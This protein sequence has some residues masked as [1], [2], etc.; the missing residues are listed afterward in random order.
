MTQ[1]IAQTIEHLTR[2]I[3]TVLVAAALVATMIPSMHAA[4]Q[5]SDSKALFVDLPPANTMVNNGDTVTIGG[6]TAGSR[7][8]IYLDG[9]AG[10]GIHLGSV[11]VGTARPDVAKATASTGLAYSGFDLAWQPKDLS[12]GPHTLYIYSLADGAW[13]FKT[14]PIMGRGNSYFVTEP[15][16][17]D[18]GP[19]SR[20]D[21]ER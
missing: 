10:V 9:P 19:D 21:N 18:R 13:T 4:A 8:D 11:T 14:V 7:V 1:A 17:L 2:P 5:G 6:W 12:A 16:R 20:D 15:E 3:R